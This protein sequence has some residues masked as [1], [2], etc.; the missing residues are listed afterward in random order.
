[1]PTLPPTHTP[2]CP[3]GLQ[4]PKHKFKEKDVKRTIA[5]PQTTHRPLGACRSLLAAGAALEVGK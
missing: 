3:I 4:L 2:H 5:E 1:M